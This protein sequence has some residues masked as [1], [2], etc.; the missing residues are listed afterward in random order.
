[1]KQNAFRPLLFVIFL[2]LTG[3]AAQ[4]PKGNIQ[5]E[6]NQKQFNTPKS[7]HSGLYIFRGQDGFFNNTNDPSSK[8]KIWVNGKELG[9][10]IRN[11]YFFTE[12]K[13]G[14]VLI[15][16]ESEFGNNDLTFEATGGRHY[17]IEQNLKMG[18]IIFGSD[19]K[20]THDEN[21]K[22]SVLSSN[23]LKKH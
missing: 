18:V 22:R 19:L 10:L 6:M 15:E 17:F 20:L 21:G 13:E 3:C 12:V 11:S 7:N 2:L 1:M 5:D 9:G 16:T 4:A 23:L 8:K 14:M